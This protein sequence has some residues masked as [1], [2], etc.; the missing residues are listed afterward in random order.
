MSDSSSQC[1]DGIFHDT[2]L[3][4]LQ[5]SLDLFLTLLAIGINQNSETKTLVYSIISGV[6]CRAFEPHYES[7]SALLTNTGGSSGGIKG[8][9]PSRS[10]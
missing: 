2:Y 6:I 5:N 7:R 1:V 9:C 4:R 10:V 3:I 8:K